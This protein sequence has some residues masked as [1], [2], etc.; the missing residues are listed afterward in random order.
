MLKKSDEARYNRR[1]QADRDAVLRK[2]AK[3]PTAS[4]FAHIPSIPS[5]PEG[6]IPPVAKNADF[7]FRIVDGRLIPR[8]KQDL[9]YT[10]KTVKGSRHI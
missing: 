7:S 2:C 1:F 5:Y 10:T 6:Y 9:H 8:D 3:Q 4:Y